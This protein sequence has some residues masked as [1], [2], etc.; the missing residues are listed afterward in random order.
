MLIRPAERYEGTDD[1]HVVTC[2]FNPSGYRIKRVNYDVFIAS[3]RRSGIPVLTV[4]CAFGEA[5]FELS[6]ASDVL[7]IRARSVL[8]QKERLLNVAVARLPP[9]AR[10]VAWLDCDVL[11]DRPDWTVQ[12]T[13]ALD[14]FAVVQPFERCFRLPPREHV[15]D[16]DGSAWESFSAVYRRDPQLFLSGNY[17]AHGHTGFAWAARRDLLDRHGL[18]DAMVAG[19][20]DHMLPHACLGDW[21]SSCIRRIVG[22]NNPYASDLRA[23]CRRFHTDVRGSLG[24]VPGNLLHLWH[25]RMSNRR[26]VERAKQLVG[27][28]FDPKVD[29]IVGDTGAWEWASDKPELHAWAIEYFSQRDEDE[30]PEDA[31]IAADMKGP[32]VRAN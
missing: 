13:R 18:Y 27:F 9:R 8:F 10:K 23:W 19:S 1:L 16:G 12:T 30:I 3:L 28:G 32:R 15:Y 29:L 21:S 4:E 17:D 5:P 20:F 6:P 7:Q 24:F 26:Y 25:G 14:D 22:V 11:F 31:V 2:Y